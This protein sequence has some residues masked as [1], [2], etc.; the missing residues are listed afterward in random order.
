M[1]DTIVTNTPQAHDGGEGVLMSL[2]LLFV[3]AAIAIGAVMM[4]QNG[5]FQSASP[6]ADV[7]DINVTVPTTPVYAPTP[8]E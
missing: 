4:Y 8:T 7:A 6:E 3:V 1:A 5:V 2:V